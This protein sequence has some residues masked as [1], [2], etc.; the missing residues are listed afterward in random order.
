MRK[1]TVEGREIEILD[2]ADLTG[3]ILK[4]R[5]KD[6]DEV[7][8]IHSKFIK[9]IKVEEEKSLKDE[10]EL[11]M[12]ELS[13]EITKLL[14]K[15]KNIEMKCKSGKIFDMIESFNG[16]LEMNAKMS[17]IMIKQHKLLEKASK[18]LK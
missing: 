15:A 8:N 6:T 12:A 14:V 2:K 1:V 10:V 7:K 4:V 5:F 18:N 3:N 9:V 17:D 16:I 13:V 11:E